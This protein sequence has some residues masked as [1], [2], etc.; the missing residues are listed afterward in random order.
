MT[1]AAQGRA[2]KVP[3]MIG[4]TADEFTFSPRCNS[5]GGRPIDAAHYPE[6]LAQ[7]FGANAAEVARQYPAEQFGGSVPLAYSAA[8]TDGAFAC[9][10]DRM[11]DALSA[12]EPVY[13]LR[14][15]RSRCAGTRA[16]ARSAVPRRRRPLAGAAV[17]V[18][19]RRSAPLNPAQQ[20]LSEQMIDYWIGFISTGSP[21]SGW[22]SVGDAGERMS[23]QPDG[24]RVITDFGQAH[25]CPFWSGLKG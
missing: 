15:R 24:N 22:P 21:G 8:V 13:C 5:F 19:R 11:A 7:A 3:V 23:L 25:K 10:A 14:V 2:A 18:R 20:R 4:T 17:S 16:A 9:V 6:L 1:G 12:A